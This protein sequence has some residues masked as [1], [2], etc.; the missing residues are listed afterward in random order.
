[1]NYQDKK[2]KE[3]VNDSDAAVRGLSASIEMM[4][5]LKNSTDFSSWV[6]IGLTFVLVILTLVL[7]WQ[8][9]TSVEFIDPPMGNLPSFDWGK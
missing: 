4:R 9:S 8:G 2:D 5:R 6:M 3:L 1:M 7:I